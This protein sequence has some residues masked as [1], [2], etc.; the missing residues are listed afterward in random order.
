MEPDD[1]T[2]FDSPAAF[3][4][5]LE[6]NHQERDQLWVGFWK[7]HTGRSSLTWPESVDEAL[8]YG[9]IDGIRKRLDDEAYTIRFTPRRTGSTWSLRNMERFDAL[10]EAGRI[11]PAGAAAHARR[12]EDKTGIYSFEQDSPPELP[13][14]A[15]GKLRSDAKAWADWQSRPAG[16]RRQVA[17]WITSAK[18]PSTRARRLAALIEDSAAGRKVKPLR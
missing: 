3:R 6:A 5:W 1:V 9:W 4:A 7:K 14:A 10:R 13:E 18:R 17:H 15:L 11:A 8:C 12:K 2:H 16:Y